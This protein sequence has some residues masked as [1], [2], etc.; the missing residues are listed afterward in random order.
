M[1]DDGLGGLGGAVDGGSDGGQV[2]VG[3]L[4]KDVV[5][6][7]VAVGG[8]ADTD[9]DAGESGVVKG[10]D[11][12][13]EAVVSAVAAAASDP[14]AAGLD[15]DVVGDDDQ[16]INVGFVVSNERSCGGSRAVHVGFGVGD[17]G[18]L[19]FDVDVSDA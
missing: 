17:D 12:G 5:D 15:V 7:G 1:G 13:F 18:R 2:F 6:L 9:T 14:D 10:V 3:G 19:V 16:A 8:F 11:D 4:T